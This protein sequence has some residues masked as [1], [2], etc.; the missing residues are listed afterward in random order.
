MTE[1][2]FEGAIVRGMPGVIITLDMQDG[3]SID[4]PLTGHQIQAMLQLA[5]AKA[6][7]MRHE[8]YEKW[9]AGG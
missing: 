5:E 7:E 1:P 6:N 3:S 9:G 4:I 2:W 8:Q